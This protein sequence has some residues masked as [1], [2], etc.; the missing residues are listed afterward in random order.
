MKFGNI[1]KGSGVR[2]YAGWPTIAKDDDGN[3]L[4]VFS[5][6]R[7]EHICPFGQTLMVVSKDDG[8]TFS[9]PVVVVNTPFDDRDGGICCR[10]KQVLVTSFNNTLEFQKR[11]VEERKPKNADIYLD[12]IAKNADADVSE[13]CSS[14][15]VSEDG[16]KTFIKKYPVPISSPHGPIVLKDGRYLHVGRAFSIE[17]TDIPRE[18]ET[19]E[20]PEGVYY[21]F[22]D[23]GY[24]WT[25]PKLIPIDYK[26][27]LYCEPHVIELN[28]GEV[29]VGIRFHPDFNHGIMKTVGIVS[30]NNISSWGEPFFFDIDGMPPHFFRHSSGAII[31]TYGKRTEPRSEMAI[32]SFDDGNTWSK[33]T[34]I[35]KFS[36]SGDLGYPSSVELNDGKILTA[37]YQHD[38]GEVN[39]IKYTIWSLDEIEK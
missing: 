18:H 25:E 19:N 33:P 6:N 29:L 5:G 22:S 13:V 8:L 23:D 26:N 15:S 9:D 30:K 7:Y 12:Y 27:D 20:L 34:V 16:G 3:I 11:M 21:Q 10:G 39:C 38:V 37:Y 31:M 17:R 28:N 14:I 4:C 1:Y 35:S 36:D 32:V 2:A 24:T